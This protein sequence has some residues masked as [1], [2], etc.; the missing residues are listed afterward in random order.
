MNL[1]L[2]LCQSNYKWKRNFRLNQLTVTI[3]R[4]VSK[5][6]YKNENLS[7]KEISSR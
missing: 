3:I 6:F 1:I 4:K 7:L 5:H 2:I